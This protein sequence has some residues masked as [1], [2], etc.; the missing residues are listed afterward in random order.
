MTEKE[1]LEQNKILEEKMRKLKS[2][3][4]EIK[5]IEYQKNLDENKI[6]LN[7]LRKNKDFI[8]SLFDHSRTSCSDE[9]PNNGYISDAGYARC[10][11]CFLIEIL[12]D[13][14]ENSFEVSFHMDITK[15]YKEKV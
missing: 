12:N 11:K 3:L 4:Q 1:I 15:V 10:D 14:F 5:D 8:L 9:N 13:E 6:K 7:E 2:Q